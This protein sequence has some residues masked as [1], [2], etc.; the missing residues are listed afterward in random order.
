MNMIMTGRCYR[1]LEKITRRDRQMHDIIY[2]ELDKIMAYPEIGDHLQD[3]QFANMHSWHFT[4]PHSGKLRIIYKIS[5]DKREI[6]VLAVGHRKNVYD[7]LMRYLGESERMAPSEDMVPR[8]QQPEPEARPQLSRS[9]VCCSLCGQVFAADSLL[10]ERRR[11]HEQYHRR[12]GRNAITGE[13]KWLAK[14]GFQKT[15]SR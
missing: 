4:H 14:D 15:R 6:T 9:Q 12:V 7:D 5:N 3:P 8:P 13:V 10:D 1:Q 11:R 2:A